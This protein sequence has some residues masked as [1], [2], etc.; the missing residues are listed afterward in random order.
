[1]MWRIIWLIRFYIGGFFALPAAVSVILICEPIIGGL[2]GY[3]AFGDQDVAMAAA[4]LAAY[5]LQD[6]LPL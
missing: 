2:F 4:A 3:G 1:M 6:C 5:G